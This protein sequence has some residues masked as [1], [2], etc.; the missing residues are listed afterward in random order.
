M[1]LEVMPIITGCEL[2][3][4]IKACQPWDDE[5]ALKTTLVDVVAVV[6]DFRKMMR[7]LQ[8]QACLQNQV[9]AILRRSIATCSHKDEL[10]QF[11]HEI[12]LE[13]LF[14]NI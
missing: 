5:F 4:R 13:S 10:A 8:T 9:T 1:V 2:K 6:A 12:D 7:R 3:E 11:C 14:D